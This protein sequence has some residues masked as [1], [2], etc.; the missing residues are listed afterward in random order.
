VVFSYRTPGRFA[1]VAVSL[2]TLVLLGLAT[3]GFHRTRAS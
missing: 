3:L 1:G 2:G